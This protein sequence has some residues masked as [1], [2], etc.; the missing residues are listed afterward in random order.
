M[1]SAA[2]SSDDVKVKFS[3]SVKNPY[4]YA[5]GLTYTESITFFSP[6]TIVQSN[7]ISVSGS[8][9]TGSGTSDFGVGF[10][11]QFLGDYS[12]IDFRHTTTTDAYADGFGFTTGV[13]AVAVPG[14]LPILSVATALCQYRKLRRLSL[15]L[16]DRGSQ[17]G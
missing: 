2:L 1:G 5:S 9:I 15:K 17:V 7:G 10:V 12:E 6:Y 4:F 8:T 16:R 11:A 13:T 14:P 3:N